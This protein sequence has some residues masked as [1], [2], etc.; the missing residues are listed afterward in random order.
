MPMDEKRLFSCL[1]G[2]FASEILLA[3]WEN[4]YAYLNTLREKIESS[5]FRSPLELLHQ[6][7]WLIH[8]SLFVYF[9][10]PK[11]L[12]DLIQL[13]L[14]SSTASTNALNIFYL[15]TLQTTSAHLLRYLAAAVIINRPKTNQR[16]LKELIKVI[17]QVC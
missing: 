3:H 15:N 1:W 16:I 8:W 14:G 4:A 7:T 12:D 9:N 6:R 11:G 2:Q 17:Q 10:H 5:T 13:F